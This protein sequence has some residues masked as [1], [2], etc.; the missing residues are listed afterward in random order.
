MKIAIIYSGFL[1]NWNGLL[2]HNN[3]YLFTGETDLF[4][5]TYDTPT[6][7][8]IKRFIK[9]P[10]PTDV[11]SVYYGLEYYTRVK[12]R[13]PDNSVYLPREKGGEH[14]NVLQQWH[15]NFMAFNIVPENYDV[16]VRSR[17]DVMIHGKIDFHKYDYSKKV[18]YCTTAVD[19]GGLNDQFAFGNYEVMKWYYSL[20]L[21]YFKKNG[22]LVPYYPEHSLLAHIQEGGIEIVRIKAEH[23]LARV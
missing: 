20:Y 21:E 1:R 14:G 9:I 17:G 4:F 11:D 7:A 19:W 12:D 23:T 10:T 15:N 6:N 8:P 5:Y 22:Y 18:L 3:M 13:H 16:Y 2:K